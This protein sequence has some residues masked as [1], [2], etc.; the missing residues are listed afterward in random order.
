MYGLEVDFLLENKLQ[1]FFLWWHRV[2]NEVLLSSCSRIARLDATLS[3]R[4]CQP[5]ELAES[6]F[7]TGIV[8]R[9]GP[10]VKDSLNGIHESI[11][12]DCTDRGII[13]RSMVEALQREVEKLTRILASHSKV[14]RNE[15]LFFNLSL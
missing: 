10:D 6:N 8:S 7:K 11:I 13:S 9:E 4:D 3:S 1:D 15:K 5:S 12:H 14:V 2:L